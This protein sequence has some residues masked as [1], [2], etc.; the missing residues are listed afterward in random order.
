MCG[1]LIF[2]LSG[3]CFLTACSPRYEVDSWNEW[4]DHEN[5]RGIAEKELGFVVSFNYQNIRE[6]FVKDYNEILVEEIV[7]NHFWDGSIHSNKEAGKLI[8]I[9]ELGFWAE[10]NNLHF[11]N[12]QLTHEIFAGDVERFKKFLHFDVLKDNTY[13]LNGFQL[14]VYK[15]IDSLFENFTI[16]TKEETTTIPLDFTMKAFL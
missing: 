13:D 7:S 15:T 2:I 5:R 8:K 14:C 12:T 4:C 6:D 3:L 9:H 11:S 1:K 10:K 16:H